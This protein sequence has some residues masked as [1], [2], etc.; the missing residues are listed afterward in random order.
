MSS[1]GHQKKGPQGNRKGSLQSDIKERTSVGK[2]AQSLHGRE[3]PGRWRKGSGRCENVEK[4]DGSKKVK[5]PV[6]KKGPGGKEEN[7]ASRA[8]KRETFHA[9][10][11]G[12][13]LRFG[14]L[15][16]TNA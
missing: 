4:K 5:R 2:K 16:V 6:K 13:R 8:E 3:V 14:V 12:S 10:T 9:A 1:H 7:L 11:Q 15:V